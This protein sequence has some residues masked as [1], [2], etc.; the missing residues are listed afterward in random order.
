MLLG[1]TAFADETSLK[2]RGTGVVNVTADVARVVLG[3]RELASDV[4][5]AQA[6]VNGKINAIYD[7]LVTAGVDPKDI[8]T[9]SIYIYANYDYDN[10]EE[11]VVGYTA[12]NSISVMVS[13]IERVGELIDTAFEAG[14]N[15]LDSVNFFSLDNSAAQKEALQLAVQSA[16]EKAEV[17]AEAAGMEILCVKSFDETEDRY[18]TDVGAK[19]SNV[20]TEGAMVD[21]STL[22][23]ASS[24]QIEASVLVEFELGKGES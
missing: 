20:R 9:E 18:T 16:Y 22:V 19:Y 14:A 21:Q 23:Q 2:V 12:V 1:C 7:A 13:Q 6:T 4:R 15:T 24:L 5:K 17:I 8:G 3:V 11:R 10:G